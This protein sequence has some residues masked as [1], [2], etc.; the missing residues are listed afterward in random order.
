MTATQ[1]ARYHTGNHWGI[2][3]VEVSDGRV[4]GARPFQQDPH[5][6]PLADAVPSAVNSKSR[7]LYPMVRKGWLEHGH[8][9]DKAGRGV[10]TMVRVSWDQALDLL[11]TELQRIKDAYGNEAFYAPSGWGSAGAFHSAEGQL[12]RFFNCFG[13]RV[14]YVTNYSFGAASVILPRI[15]GTMEPVTGPSTS[16]PVIASNTKLLVLFG[17]MSPKNSQVS[18]DGLGRHDLA[19]WQTLAKD[20]GVEFVSISP[21]RDDMAQSLGAQWLPL[22]PNTDVAMMMG[23]MHTLLQEGLHDEAFLQDYCVGFDRLRAYLLGETDGVPKSAQW[24]SEITEVDAETIRGLARRMASVRSMVNVAWSVQRAD[25]GEQP[26][27]AA[28][29]L[30]AMVGQVGLPGGG[31]GF[32]YGS[33][34]G[35]GNPSPRVAPPALPKGA[36]DVEAFIPVSRVSEMLLNPGAPFDF[37]G[38]SMT[39]PD[40]HLLYWCGGNPFHKQQDLN[41][42]L[43]A[44]EKPDTIVVNEPWWTAAARRADIALPCTTTMERNDIGASGGDRFWFAMQQAIEPMGEARSEY[45]I[46]ADLA[47]R[48]GCEQEFTEGRDEMEWLRHIYAEASNR[49]AEQ[50]METPDFDQFWQAGHVEFPAPETPQV[51]LQAFRD[52]PAGSPLRTPSGKIEIFSETIDGFGYDDCP[53]HPTW[54]S[55]VEWLGSDKAAQYPLHLIS[56]QPRYRLHSQLD[57]GEL[58]QG[59]KIADRE[60]VWMNPQDAESRGIS[61]GDVVRL[62]NDRGACLAGAYLTDQVRPGVVQLAT[63]AWFDPADP[64]EA[65]SL[66]KHGNPNVLTLDKGTSRLAQSPSAQTALVQAERYESEPPPITAFDPPE[67]AA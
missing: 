39:Y 5:P 33:S 2:F 34:S 20:K 3:D 17:G 52:N 38:R 66:D 8:R 37:N 28:V 43:R 51:L 7:I 62:F 12:T 44:W 29:A 21:I 24:A 50:G 61:A 10:E 32:G 27:W 14:G 49:A 59:R 4:V 64:G 22:R 54:M 15:I 58:S 67:G 35:L 55:P 53:G 30:A 48:L 6:S 60:P 13:G 40:I 23:M 57:N 65:G 45:R 56:N 1:P 19:D 18:K 11:A 25:H 31:F 47:A 41:M 42:L 46:Y 16:W 36:S 63:G 9:S 26:Y